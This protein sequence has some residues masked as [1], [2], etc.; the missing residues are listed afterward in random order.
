MLIFIHNALPTSTPI[1]F[2]FCSVYKAFRISVSVISK[3]VHSVISCSCINIIRIH[4]KKSKQMSK[5]GFFLSRSHVGLNSG[6]SSK[7]GRIPTKSEWLDSLYCK[8]RCQLLE[9]LNLETLSF[10]PP[11]PTPLPTN[12]PSPQWECSVHTKNC[13]HF[14]RTTLDFQGKLTRDTIS[15]IIQ[16]CTFPVHSNKTLRLE[17]FASPTSLHFSVHLS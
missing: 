6:F 16:K 2:I 10:S 7:I 1:N 9:I 5:L 15:Q 14:S 17:Q 13:N 11:Q 8:Q 12:W 4:L 3:L